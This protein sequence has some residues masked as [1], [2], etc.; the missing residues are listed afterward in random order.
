EAFA[1]KPPAYGRILNRLDKTVRDWNL[2]NLPPFDQLP[3]TEDAEVDPRALIQSLST[4]ALREIALMYLHRRYFVEALTKRSNEPLRSKY[5]MSV[6]AVHR[7]A[8]TLLQG[9]LRSVC[10]A[11]RIFATMSFM[12]VHA[13]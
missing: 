7:S 1:V 11:E 5:A 9:I 12:W 6:L 8:T 4:T 2:G 10:A 3:T 13:L